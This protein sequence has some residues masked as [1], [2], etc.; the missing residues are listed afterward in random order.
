[1]AL[2]DTSEGPIDEE[3]L[4]RTDGEID[5]ATRFGAFREYRR[6]GA[7][8]GSPA[9]H[10]SE[11]TMFL[12]G[13][14]FDARPEVIDAMGPGDEILRVVNVDLGTGTIS[15]MA[16]SRLER[17]TGT[18]DTADEFA[19]WVEYRIP[20]DP[21]IVHRSADVKLKRLTDGGRALAGSVV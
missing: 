11:A 16:V 4:D 20:G 3:F 5:D 18:T 7:E 15:T 19:A 12:K 2:I 13:N 21:R 17:T 14:Q 10:R 8:A 6:K 9:I 1:M